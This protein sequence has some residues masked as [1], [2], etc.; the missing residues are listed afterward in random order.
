[1]QS[2]KS[3]VGDTGVALITRPITVLVAVKSPAVRE[4]LVATIDDLEGFFVG[5]E[6]DSAEE[7]LAV[8]RRLR[9]TLAVVDEDLPD[10][11]GS[12]VIQTLASQRL[13]QAVL[14]IGLRGDGGRRAKAAGAVTYIQTGTEPRE[15]V[16]AIR[17]AVAET[18]VA[19]TCATERP[20]AKLSGAF[21]H[22]LL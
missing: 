8:A 4:A 14:A 10:C 16:A 22:G 15:L 13:A 6:A 20:V 2:S 3:T 21:A 12:D 11:C 5:G 7:A 1:M 18:T 9:P 19:P 17:A